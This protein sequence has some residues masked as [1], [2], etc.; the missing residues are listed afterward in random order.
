MARCNV[1]FTVPI[2]RFV[3]WLADRDLERH[4]HHWH[5]GHRELTHSFAESLHM[6]QRFPMS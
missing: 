1:D 3:E 4:H 5:I 2:G 6:P